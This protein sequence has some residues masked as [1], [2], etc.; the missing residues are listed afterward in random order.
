M[1][2]YAE[3]VFTVDGQ[4]IRSTGRPPI[5]DVG[6]V[7]ASRRGHAEILLGPDAVLWTGVGAQVRFDDTSIAD[8][9]VTLLTGSLI[10][11]VKRVMV[12]N[13][14]QVQLGGRLVEVRSVGVYRFDLTPER[15]QVFDG[16][17]L[18]P[19]S[20]LKAARGQEIVDSSSRAFDT[21]DTDEFLHWAALR[22][23]TLERDSGREQRWRRKG[24]LDVSH[25]GFG[26][27]LP[28][29]LAAARIKYL[30]AA[31]A[32]LVYSV[33]GPT[34][35]RLPTWIDQNNAVR[36]RA[37]KAEVFLG[38]GVVAHV[39][40]NSAL[41]ILDSRAWAPMAA[42]EQGV[43]LIEVA[44]S[45]EFPVLRLQ[46]GETITHLLSPGVYEVD[47][48]AGTVSVYR[49]E[50]Q[51]TLGSATARVRE[52]QRLTL[53]QPLSTSSFDRK[54]QDALFRWAAEVSFGLY[55]LNAGFMTGWTDDVI[56]YKAKH[57]VFGVR[58]YYGSRVPARPKP[59]R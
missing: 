36:T 17:L 43:V 35:Q 49:G 27:T 47:A 59:F 57:K 18:I 20:N 54:Q 46:V 26:M 29:D 42:L 14:L 56:S 38:V 30:A 2:Y 40:E 34:D 45:K 51:T 19:E 37:A 41:R 32:G 21:R 13:R 6:Q 25:A 3:G 50:S 15:I 31:R 48:Q 7:A 55:T 8:A 28:R 39:G 5:L 23:L 52:G 58:N 12:G 53:A 9:R 24:L 1:I 22:S 44:E 11:E 10:I 4:T 33:Q 16:D